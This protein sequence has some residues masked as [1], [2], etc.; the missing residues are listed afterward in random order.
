MTIT[1]SR[2]LSIAVIISILLLF[3]A[4]FNQVN[5]Q[6]LGPRDPAELEAFLD[7]VLAEQMTNKHVAGITISA[8]DAVGV[9]KSS[10]TARNS[11]FLYA[12][13]PLRASLP[14]DKWAAPKPIPPFSA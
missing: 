10:D 3:L 2:N 13:L 14:T 5:A 7:G 4:P 1:K 12:S 6:E 11:N 8:T 9:M